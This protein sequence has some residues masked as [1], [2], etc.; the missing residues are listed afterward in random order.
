[1][2]VV[3]RRTVVGV[4]VKNNSLKKPVGR[5]SGN[6]RLTVLSRPFGRCQTADNR[7]SVG[8]LSVASLLQYTIFIV[9]TSS[10]SNA[11]VGREMYSL[12]FR[13]NLASVHTG[14]DEI[15]ISQSIRHI[16][17][18]ISNPATRSLMN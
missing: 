10:D 7:Q 3:L 18:V 2:S 12:E 8:D 16:G 4:I 13:P 14:I 6:C 17:K 11:T 1:M 15:L 5:Q 9:Q